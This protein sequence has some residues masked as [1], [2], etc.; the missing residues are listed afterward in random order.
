MAQ[1]V[2]SQPIETE[3]RVVE[4]TVTRDTLPPGQHR[5][6]LI[7]TD[8][9]G[10]VSAPAMFEVVVRDSQTSRNPRCAAPGRCETKLTIFRESLDR[11]RIREDRSLSMDNAALKK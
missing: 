8:D 11:Y 2:P 7:V 1:F 6:R 3:T 4:V 9:A 5:F 10:N